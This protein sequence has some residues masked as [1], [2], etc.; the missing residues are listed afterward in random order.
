[1]K[2][3]YMTSDLIKYFETLICPPNKSVQVVH[4]NQIG[5]YSWDECSL[6][7]LIVIGSINKQQA[8][9]LYLALKPGAHL[10]CIPES[11]LDVD[12]VIACEDR[13]F[14]VRDAIF[15]ATEHSSFFYTSKASKKERELGLVSE[16]T[17][18]RANTHPTVKP[19]A[20]MEY[21]LRDIQPN[22]LV[23]DPFMGSGTTGC[24]AVRRNLNFI[25]IEK[26]AVYAEIAQKRIDAHKDIDLIP[27][28]YKK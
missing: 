27:K 13:G 24:A 22:A 8:D 6:Y 1:M 9:S 16:T 19:I 18:R 20:I 3:T 12:S 2:G 28:G 7:G 26:E 14:E 25:G 21:M 11:E 17:D 23:V 15:N 10:V 4:A 5:S